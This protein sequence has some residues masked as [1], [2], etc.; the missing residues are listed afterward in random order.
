MTTKF[1]LSTYQGYIISI[2]IQGQCYYTNKRLPAKTV[3]IC[4][5]DGRSEIPKILFKCNPAGK[6]V[7]GSPQKDGNINF[8]CNQNLEIISYDNVPLSK[9]STFEAGTANKIT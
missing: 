7:P 6:R 3:T 4:G 1:Q 8:E 9:Y 5:N 2:F